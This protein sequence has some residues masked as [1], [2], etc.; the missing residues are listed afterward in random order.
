[1]KNRLREAGK[2]LLA[3]A[4]GLSISLFCMTGSSVVRET[5]HAETVPVVMDESGMIVSG[6]GTG[7]Y[8]DSY[9][10]NNNSGIVA[11][12]QAGFTETVALFLSKL[13]ESK[14]TL[15]VTAGVFILAVGCLMFSRKSI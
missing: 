13:C 2:F 7:T 4:I 1:M 15:I 10:V 6:N 3:V 5:V 12:Q 11:S 9:N 14:V 8:V